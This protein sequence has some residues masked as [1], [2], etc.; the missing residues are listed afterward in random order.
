MA[1]IKDVAERAGVTVTTVSRVLNNRGYI[2]QETR[3][4]V[5]RVMQ[6]INYQPNEIARSLTRKRSMIL[7][8]IIPAIAHPFFAE[9]TNHIER[10]ASSLGYKILLCNSRLDQQKEKDYIDM[11]KSNRVDG[12]F[13]ASHTLEID[14]Y[15]KLARP[16]VTFDRRIENI[17]FVSSDNEQ[18]GALVAE[19]LMSKQCRKIAHISGNLQLDLLSNRRTE[20]FVRTLRARSVEPVLVELGPDVFEAADNERVIAKLF[21][22]HPDV[23][24]IFASGDLLA[25]NVMQACTA[26]GIAVPDRVKLVGY[27]D[28]EVA[29]LMN[30]SL[31]TVKQPLEAMARRVV[32][33]LDAMIAGNDVPLENVLPVTLIERGST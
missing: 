24:G 26:R 17:P 29:K 33:L 27:D 7:G 19:L 28:I 32:E 30:P 3:E 6:E 31:T 16:V 13:M 1:T 2:S 5:Y 11:L 15:K 25:L 10:Y 21:A 9:L 4:K 23:D 12:V 18:G 22:E 8:V 20:S 14:E